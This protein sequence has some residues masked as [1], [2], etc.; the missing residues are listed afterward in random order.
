[1][2]QTNTH[3]SLPFIALS[4]CS[5]QQSLTTNSTMAVSTMTL[6][7]P[8]FV[9]K[10][11]Q[12]APST[13]E[14]GIGR[15]IMSKI[16]TMEAHGTAQTMSSTWVHYLVSPRLTLLENSLVTMVGTLLGFLLTQKPLPRTIRELEV[17]HCRWAMLGALGC[18]FPELLARNGVSPNLQRGWA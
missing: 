5:F 1:M 18:V 6:S 3:H 10:A 2:I 11:V 17:I 16:A 13:P 12:L 9:G 8:S 14:L 7:S 15:V 4:N